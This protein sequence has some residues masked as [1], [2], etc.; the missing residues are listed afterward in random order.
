MP[1]QK[2]IKSASW[3]WFRAELVRRLGEDEAAALFAELTERRRAER[4]TEQRKRAAG[5]IA[6]FETQLVE[7]REQGRPTRR[8]EN[9]IARRRELLGGEW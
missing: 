1:G 6:Y 9:A 5:E 4:T 8:V 7:L 3:A 2:P